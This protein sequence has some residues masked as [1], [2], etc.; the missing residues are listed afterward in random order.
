[1]EIL[2][3]TV[4]LMLA[5]AALF[6]LS[7]CNRPNGSEVTTEPDV[8]GEDPIITTEPEVTTEEP[9]VTTEAPEEQEKPVLD[10]SKTYNILFVGNSYTYYNDMPEKYF[11]KI[12]ESA[13]YNVTVKSLTKGAQQ[14]VNSAKLTD[15]LGAKI[16]AELKENKYDFIILQDQST[17]ALLRNALFVSGMRSMVAMVRENGATP[18]LYST[19]GSKE[20]RSTLTENNWTTESMMWQIAAAYEKIGNELD[21]EVANVGMA[22]FDV[23]TNN[24]NIN[25]YNEDLSH[26]SASGSY[27]AA[28]T[29]FAEITGVDPTT[30]SYNGP[31]IKVFSDVLKEAARKAVFETPKIPAEYK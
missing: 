21:V 11:K 7:A 4:L 25:L 10:K 30:V 23:H 12:M 15:E 24:A 8:T 9:T 26:P 22:F 27:L 16:H 13:G 5:A 28:L 2:K 29:I 14:L 31:L 18:I 17:Q 19:W 1:M 20:G 3:Q 6:T